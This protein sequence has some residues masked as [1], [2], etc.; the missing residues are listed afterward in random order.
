MFKT[1]LSGHIKIWGAMHP[2][3]CGHGSR[4][5][6]VWNPLVYRTNFRARTD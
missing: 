6:K 1:H 3:G 4:Y 2:G 5:N